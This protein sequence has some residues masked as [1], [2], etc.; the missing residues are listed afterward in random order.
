MRRIL[1]LWAAL[2]KDCLLLALSGTLS[3]RLEWM[4]LALVEETFLFLC[5]VALLIDFAEEFYEVEIG[6]LLRKLALAC[7]GQPDLVLDVT[8]G[9]VSGC[10][11]TQS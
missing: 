11:L 1:Q 2:R 7:V 8:P 3:R 6:A 9:E 10:L 5:A 4:P